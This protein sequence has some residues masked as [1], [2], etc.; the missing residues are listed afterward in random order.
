[1]RVLVIDD[2]P[3]VRAAVCEVLRELG[4]SDV[5]VA[6]SARSALTLVTASTGH[7]DLPERGDF[8]KCWP[9]LHRYL[10]DTRPAATMI[11][12]G[13]SD[14]HRKIEIEVTARRQKRQRAADA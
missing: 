3:P 2:Q 9:V 1:M 6:S 10:G 14:P 12:A 7:F 8:A 4:V 13:L 5:T 11:V